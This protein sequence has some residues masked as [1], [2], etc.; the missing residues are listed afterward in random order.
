MECR[1][2]RYIDDLFRFGTSRKKELK[3]YDRISSAFVRKK[4]LHK[5][6]K[7][8][9]PIKEPLIILSVIFHKDGKIEPYTKKMTRLLEATG[10]YG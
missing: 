8:Q 7:C 3:V 4:L 6:T 2:G 10:I 1:L 5:P 9:P